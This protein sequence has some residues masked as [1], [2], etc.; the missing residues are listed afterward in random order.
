MQNEEAEQRPGRLTS[1]FCILP[2]EICLPRP[3]Y[4]DTSNPR[5]SLSL[6]GVGV[7]PVLSR[8]ELAAETIAVKIR[9]FGILFGYLL[10]NFGDAGEHRP[11]L[12]A[13]LALGV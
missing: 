5:F 11:I 3:R 1:A 8:W 2:S 12:N 6:I 13:I 7:Q 9:W 4:N 10:V